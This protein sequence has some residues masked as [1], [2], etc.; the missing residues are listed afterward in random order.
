MREFVVFLRYTY[1][2]APVFSLMEEA[3]LKKMMEVIGW[4][5][6]GDGIFNAGITLNYWIENVMCSSIHLCFNTLCA[7]FCPGG[8]MSNMYAVN[9]ARYR[10]CPDI[11]EDGLSAAPRLVM[12][13]SQEVRR[14]ANEHSEL[15]RC[16][17]VYFLC[18]I[19]SLSQLLLMKEG[20]CEG[21]NKYPLSHISFTNSL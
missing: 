2:V 8:S 1:E 19:W 12:F 4:E 11:K 10:H 14:T 18:M 9:L 13:T 16:T 7:A 17:L 6:G 15:N 3:V 20:C 5:E 21:K